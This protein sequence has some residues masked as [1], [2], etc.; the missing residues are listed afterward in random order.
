MLL[1]LI[2]L[3]PHALLLGSSAPPRA[4]RT[5]V[6]NM[7]RQHYDLVV[8]GGGPVGITAALRAAS[9]GRTSILIDATPPRLFQF[10]GPTGLYSKALRDSALRIDVGVLKSMGISDEAI[11]NQLSGFVEQIM[12]K[13]GDNNAKAL[14]VNRVPHL[15]GLGSLCAT[16]DDGAPGRCT[17]AAEFQQPR[18]K[19]S[20]IQ[21]RA[22]NVLLATGSKAVRLPS[23]NDWYGCDVGG[24]VRVHDSDSIRGLTFLPR[25]VVVVGG[26]IIA[27]EFARIFSELGADVTMVIRSPDL[28]KSLSRVGIDREVGFVLQADLQAAGVRLLF[29]SEIVGADQVGLLGTSRKQVGRQGLELSV[30]QS[31]TKEPREP[32]TADLVLTATGRS[33]VTS[34][35][36]LDELGVRT[37]RNGDVE[38]D[39]SLE[40]SCAGVFAAGDV[41]G[42]P[43][44]ASTGIAQAEAAVDAMFCRAAA[45][46]TE[47]PEDYSPAALLANT[48]RYPIGIWTLPEVAFVGLTAEAAEQPPHNLEIIEGIGRYSESI[49]GHVHTVGTA[50]EGEYLV[51]CARDDDGEGCVPLT[52]PSLKLV[53]TRAAPHHV[54][55]V[56]IYGDDACELIHF[57]TTLVQERKTLADILAM[58]FTAVTYHELYK[59]AARDALEQLDAAA[60]RQVYHSL[61]M[62]GD[63]DGVLTPDEVEA[64]LV[65]LGATQNEVDGVL[66]ALFT[67]N[68]FVGIEQ[69]VRRAQRLQSPFRLELMESA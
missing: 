14:G 23:L 67:G 35:L 54:V 28:P 36:S 46:E 59:L 13:S 4:R 2:S 30:V 60:W 68:G 45:T 24:H 37:Q 48:A 44:L 34:G 49:R 10:T 7:L 17:V 42:A 57:G 47:T 61:D 65:K 20:V 39:A 26:G 58:C 33:A 8:V 62:A 64:K 6:P 21:L 25:E 32:L 27:I 29:N 9:L 63:G 51:P 31:Q 16:P 19:A 15:R 11:W 18:A 1:G 12:R 41:I 3:L 55:G 52:G 56:H 22:D 40:T 50:L 5:G 66:R 38:V 43:Q 53:V 69:F